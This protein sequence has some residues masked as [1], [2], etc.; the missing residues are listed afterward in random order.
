MINDYLKRFLLSHSNPSSL[1]RHSFPGLPG[2]VTLHHYDKMAS[3]HQLYDLHSS[4]LLHIT[5][6]C[7]HRLP[8]FFSK[9]SGSHSNNGNRSVELQLSFYVLPTI[10]K[11]LTHSGLSVRKVY[12]QW[13]LTA[14]S[15]TPYHQLLSPSL[16][17]IPT[18]SFSQGMGREANMPTRYIFLHSK[19]TLT[20]NI[21]KIRFFS[22][23]P[24]KTTA[25]P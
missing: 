10:L 11:A 1:R 13:Q 16:K 9:F 17:T 20:N 8:F 23:P 7:I 18:S 14:C 21:C 5:S 24:T 6:T 15:L 19:K 12:L 3:P 2:L 4:T 22:S 25:S